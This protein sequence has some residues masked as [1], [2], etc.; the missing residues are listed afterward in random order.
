VTTTVY[1]IQDKEGRG[2]YRLGFS[3]RWVDESRAETGRP[4]VMEEFGWDFASKARPEHFVGCAFRTIDQL[5]RY[6]TGLEIHRLYSLGYAI[7][8][9][10]A[11]EILH[12][13]ESQLVIARK[14]RLHSGV[15][16][17]TLLTAPEYNPPLLNEQSNQK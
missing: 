4:S 1:R 8:Q 16:R 11:D 5:K 15:K 6:F 3:H 10:E 7:T 12:E 14:K 17:L 13:S 9:M 2:P